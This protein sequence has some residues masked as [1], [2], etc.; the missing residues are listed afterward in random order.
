[1]VELLPICILPGTFYLVVIDFSNL[2]GKHLVRWNKVFI[3]QLFGGFHARCWYSILEPFPWSWGPPSWK[4]VR[5]REVIRH[6]S[7]LYQYCRLV[8]RDMLVV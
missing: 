5:V 2:I 4:G 1:M 8:P 7:Q 3:F 6:E